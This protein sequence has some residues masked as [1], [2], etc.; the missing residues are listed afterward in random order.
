MNGA[1]SA[2]NQVSMKKLVQ[3]FKVVMEDA[4]ALARA[5]AGDLGE[6]ARDARTRLA[7]SLESAKANLSTLQGKA[8]EG[9]KV[10][11]QMI[12]DH[13]YETMGVA[14]GVG[15]LLGVLINRK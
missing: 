3:D 12:R 11:D 1:E 6:K 9:A 14:F 13:P 7:S 5:T 2:E 4:E 15:M 10:T 8:M